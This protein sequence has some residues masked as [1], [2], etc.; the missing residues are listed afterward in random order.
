MK[1]FITLMLAIV[2]IFTLCS[3]GSKKEEGEKDYGPGSNV[4]TSA[5]IGDTYCKFD[6][7]KNPGGQETGAVFKILIPKEKVS[8]KKNVEIEITLADEWKV[9]EE[10]NCIVSIANNSLVLDLSVDDPKLVVFAGSDA[11]TRTYHLI[12]DQYKEV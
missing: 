8:D 4:I 10:S 6:A 7:Y 3:C 5:K 2:L 12:L 11:Y 9:S 1:K